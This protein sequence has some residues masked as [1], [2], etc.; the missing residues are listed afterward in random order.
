MNKVEA[1]Q[2]AEKG[3]E[4]YRALSYEEIYSRLG[5]Q[6]NFERVSDDGEPYRIEID[7]MFDDEG[8]KTIRVSGI[9]SFSGWTDFS[10]VSSSFIINRNGE[11]MGE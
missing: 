9:V 4:F 5:G 3:L 8:Q 10:P 1:M 6:E 11:F 2:N 7:F